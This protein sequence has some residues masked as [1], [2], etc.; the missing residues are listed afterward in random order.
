MV[1]HESELMKRWGSCLI[2]CSAYHKNSNA[3]GVERANCVVSNT[4]RTY[5]NG[6]KD[7]GDLQL[8]L[9]VY[10]IHMAASTLGGDLSLVRRPQCAPSAPAVRTSPQASPRHTTRSECWLWR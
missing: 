3:K 1:D 6:R 7:G 9:A 4:L 8:P 5:A 10:A 2:I